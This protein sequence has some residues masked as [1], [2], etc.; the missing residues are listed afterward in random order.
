VTHGEVLGFPVN[1]GIKIVKVRITQDEF[2]L[3]RSAFNLEREI[4]FNQKSI[5]HAV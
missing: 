5:F 2:I 3:D 1:T 4:E